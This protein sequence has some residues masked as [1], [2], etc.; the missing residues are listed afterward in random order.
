MGCLSAPSPGEWHLGRACLLCTQPPVWHCGIMGTLVCVFACHT[1]RFQNAF[2]PFFSKQ[3]G[4][5]IQL[6]ES[7]SSKPSF[8]I[9]NRNILV[10]GRLT[11]CFLSF[12]WTMLCFK[13]KIWF[14][15]RPNYMISPT[16]DIF[17]RNKLK[18]FLAT[19]H[20]YLILCGDIFTNVCCTFCARLEDSS[21]SFRI[22]FSFTVSWLNEIWRWVLSDNKSSRTSW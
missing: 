2:K 8:L 9:N 10:S 13:L 12:W 3:P 16:Y 6:Q 5:Y 7:L 1:S 21:T 22:I 11:G 14:L 17:L 18:Y 15:M 19:D 20:S 4:K